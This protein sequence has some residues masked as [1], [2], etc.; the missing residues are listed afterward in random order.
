MAVSKIKKTEQLKNL[1]S[2]LGSAKSVVV[3]DYTGL[4]VNQTNDLRK[5]ISESEG[6]LTIAKNSLLEKSLKDAKIVPEVTLKGQSA[7]ITS[8]GDYLAL[9]KSLFAFIK[10]A[11]MPKVG[12]GVFDGKRMELAEIKALS[13]IPSREILLGRLM[14]SIKSPMS[15]LV[16]GLAEVAK[17]KSEPKEVSI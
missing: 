15:K 12:F 8:S 2:L 16:I 7:L 11:E 3:A 14:G 6:T 13:E 9:I 5:K 10:T 17:K 1:K 4:S